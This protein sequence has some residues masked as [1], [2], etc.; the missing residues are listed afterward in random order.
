MCKIFEPEL[1]RRCD[2]VVLADI[3]VDVVV[4]VVESKLEDIADRQDDTVDQ[5]VEA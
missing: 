5:V 3:V 4:V 2:V 1:D